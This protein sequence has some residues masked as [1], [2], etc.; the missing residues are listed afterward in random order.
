MPTNVEPES[1]ESYY[2]VS[3]RLATEI[4]GAFKPD[5]SPQP[6]QPGRPLRLDRARAVGAERRADHAPR[7]RRRDRRHHHRHRALPQGAQSRSRGRRRGSGRLD[8]HRPDPGRRQ[9]L[10]GRGRRRGLLADDLR[11]V[12]RGPLGP[13]ERPRL[14]PDHAPARDDR[15]HPDRRLLRPRGARR[16]RGRRR[17]R[18]SGGHGRGDPARRRALLLQQDLLRRV[19]DRVRL[20]RAHRRGVR[21]RR[22]A[23]QARR[24]DP[25]ARHRPQRPVRPQGRLPAARAPGVA[26]PRRLRTRRAR[27]RRVD[28]RARRAQARHR[29]PGR[30][31]RADRRRDEPRFPVSRSR[32]PSATPS[33][34]CPA[35]G[36]RCSSPATASRR[37]IL[38]R[39]DLLE[40]LAS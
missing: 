7:R 13:R 37:S 21:R 32:R 39:A 10:H 40:S 1:P 2:S 16:A 14:L 27:G 6:G 19:D 15:G 5:R 33:S 12:G 18:R 22:P 4:P 28:R 26:A 11:P 29:R 35:T 30:A 3:D 34:C 36:R 9:G 23:A 24:H 38:T 17:D 25:R 31:R 8:L 20:P